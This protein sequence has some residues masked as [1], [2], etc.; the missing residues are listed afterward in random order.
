MTDSG[1]TLQTCPLCQVGRLHPTRTP[2]VHV[3][4]D[5]LVQVPGI[6]GWKCDICGLTLFESAAVR[7]IELLID[8]DGL[9]PNRHPPA[10]GRAPARDSVAPGEDLPEDAAPPAD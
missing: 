6:A 7:R 10:P 2:Y 3:Y 1:D 5:T 9:P 4:E 8:A